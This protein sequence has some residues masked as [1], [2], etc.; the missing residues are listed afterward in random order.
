MEPPAKSLANTSIDPQ[1]V[2]LV[3]DQNMGPGPKDAMM[4]VMIGRKVVSQ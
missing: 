1:I 4:V 3:V 2:F